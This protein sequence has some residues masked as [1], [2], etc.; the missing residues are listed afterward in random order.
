MGLKKIKFKYHEIIKVNKKGFLKIITELP[1][2]IKEPT[3]Y[4]GIIKVHE[5]SQ[6]FQN[7]S[8]NLNSLDSPESSFKYLNGNN[9]GEF[10]CYI[11][12]YVV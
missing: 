8:I 1:K 5:K 3:N 12:S 11:R 10:C 2:L 4:H 7:I 6:K 9:D